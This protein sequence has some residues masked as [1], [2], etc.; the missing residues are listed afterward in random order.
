MAER[1]AE[2]LRNPGIVALQ[3][4]GSGRFSIKDAI[5]G[6]L[7]LG[8]LGAIGGLSLVFAATGYHTINAMA[9]VTIPAAYGLGFGLL[10]F[11]G[12]GFISA[13]RS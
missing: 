6:G 3:E 1:R 7:I 9:F 8:A 12:A 11:I 10:G 5:K 2:L 13:L 4:K